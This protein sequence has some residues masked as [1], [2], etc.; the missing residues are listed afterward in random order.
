MIR[1]FSRDSEC[2]KW[3]ASNVDGK[4]ICAQV[5][6]KCGTTVWNFISDV[7]DKAPFLVFIK[8]LS[9]WVSR[10]SFSVENPNGKGV[11]IVGSKCFHDFQCP[12]PSKSEPGERVRMMG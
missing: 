1:V 11:F 2:E 8:L 12:G 3:H 5:S 9:F 6:Y 4:F 10:L 7:G